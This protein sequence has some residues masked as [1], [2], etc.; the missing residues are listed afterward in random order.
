M[1]GALVGGLTPLSSTCPRARARARGG[2]TARL[3]RP[4]DLSGAIRPILGLGK[5]PCGIMRHH[6]EDT[7]SARPFAT[8][9]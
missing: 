8:L 2:G 4:S 6:E 9:R 5:N 3:R 1:L 7:E